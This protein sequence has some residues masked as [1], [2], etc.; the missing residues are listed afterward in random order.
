MIAGGG[1][2]ADS[3]SILKELVGP[4]NEM[5]FAFMHH[6]LYSTEIF[7][8]G[9]LDQ[10][11]ARGGYHPIIYENMEEW[12]G[13]IQNMIKDKVSAV[14]I[15][16]RHNVRSTRMEIDGVKYIGNAFG[17]PGRPFT[18]VTIEAANGEFTNNIHYLPVPFDSE[19][20]KFSTDAFF[21][22]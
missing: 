18:Y 22:N 1:L 15:R 19:W 4:D 17:L 7:M 20:Y 5:N 9:T 16:D 11:I 3:K 13:E 2:D 10:A 14:Y 12:S 8:T 21:W 6:T